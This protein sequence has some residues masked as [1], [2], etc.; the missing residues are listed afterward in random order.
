MEIISP[1]LLIVIIMWSKY[2]VSQGVLIMTGSYS[3]KCGV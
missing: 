2:V 1:D 3:L